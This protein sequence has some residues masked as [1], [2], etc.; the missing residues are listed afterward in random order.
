MAS[1]VVLHHKALTTAEDLGESG[2]Y[3]DDQIFSVTSQLLADVT[4]QLPAIFSCAA[5]AA[6][7]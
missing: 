7:A 5:A 6:S 4:G 2:V 3:Q 1:G